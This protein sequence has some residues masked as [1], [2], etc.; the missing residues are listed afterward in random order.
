MFTVLAETFY[1][2]HIS[3]LLKAQADQHTGNALLLCILLQMFKCT[4]KLEFQCK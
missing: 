4:N 2:L 3:H 1:V